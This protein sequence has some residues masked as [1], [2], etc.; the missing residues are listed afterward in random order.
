M[1]SFVLIDE[2]KIYYFSF[3]KEIKVNDLIIVRCLL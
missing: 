3:D 2:E 1:V